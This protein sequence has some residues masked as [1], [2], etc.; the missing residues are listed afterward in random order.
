MDIA[1]LRNKIDTYRRD[2]LTNYDF[3]LQD[4]CD[5]IISFL[6]NK[7]EA[8][9]KRKFKDFKKVRKPEEFNEAIINDM[10]DVVSYIKDWKIIIKND[11]KLNDEKVIVIS[12]SIF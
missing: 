12:E 9:E 10:Y 4:K 8:Y 6:W 5:E 1:W 2:I 7:M 11:K 3:D